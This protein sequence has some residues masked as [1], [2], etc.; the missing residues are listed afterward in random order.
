LDDLIDSEVFCCDTV[1]DTT[2]TPPD[3]TIY[4]SRVFPAM[5][6]IFYPRI[7]VAGTDPSP[8]DSTILCLIGF[9]GY[10]QGSTAPGND[11]LYQWY[12]IYWNA[13]ENANVYYDEELKFK[14]GLSKTLL[15]IRVK[16][17]DGGAPVTFW[18]DHIRATDA[19]FNYMKWKLSEGDTTSLLEKKDINSSK[20]VQ[21][22]NNQCKFRN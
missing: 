9:A 18:I 13:F 14:V 16:T 15:N 6:Y 22:Y 2:V 12:P 8:G 10:D 5:G 20:L 1:I 19:F 7:R 21:K 17:P 4:H 11:S 3:T